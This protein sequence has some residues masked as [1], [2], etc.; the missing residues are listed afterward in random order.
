MAGDPADAV[1]LWA[2][3]ARL[4]AV[5]TGPAPARVATFGLLSV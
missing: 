1:P 4:A 3:G 5:L 2:L